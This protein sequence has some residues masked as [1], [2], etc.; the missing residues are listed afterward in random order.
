M[1]ADIA[2]RLRALVRDHVEGRYDA[3]TYR[4]LRAELLDGLLSPHA[5]P[6]AEITQSREALDRE[7]ITQPRE[8]VARS[9]TSE[10]SAATAA[11]PTPPPPA[12]PR[13]A[14]ELPKASPLAKIG[15][16]RAGARVPALA[17]L[18]LLVAVGATLLLWHYRSPA[19][20]PPP[21]RAAS[22]V[23]NRAQGPDPI[24]TLLQPLIDDGDWSDSSVVVLNAAL[25]KFPAAQIAAERNADWFNVALEVVRFR[26]K[27]QQ[28]L[29]SAPLSPDTSPI[30][31]LAQTL[32][33]ELARPDEP[34]PAPK[35]PDPPG[36]GA[37]GK[38]G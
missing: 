11:E 30:A 8:A 19:V 10:P 37:A 23:P 27:Q 2:E 21:P 1:S 34:A 38:G 24:H 33:I 36:K 14:Q 17:A 12:M 26:L 9:L 35:S 7:L 31:A 20:A 3:A 15:R 6:A 18:G 4:R 16:R 5:T 28:A 29:A 22:G 25:R 13:G 32:G